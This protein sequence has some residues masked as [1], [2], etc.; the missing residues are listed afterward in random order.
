M[1]NTEQFEEGGTVLVRPP[2]LYLNVLVIATCGLV[3]ELI[4]GTLASYVLGDSV[5][6]FSTC[7]GVYLSAL[8][9][10]AWLSRFVD[11][12]TARCFI[13]VELGVALLGGLS[14][15]ILFLAFSHV[16][17]FHAALYGVVFAIGTLVG[18]ELP[19][20]MRILREQLEFKELVSRVLTF[21]YIGALVGSLLF[22]I[23]LVPSLGL[24]RTSLVFGMLNAAVALWGTWLLEPL[25]KKPPGPLRVRAAVVMV[26]LIVAFIKADRLTAIAEEQLFAN[27][28]V[29][30]RTTRYQRV[31]VTQG[32]SGFQLF[33][34]GNLQFNSIDEYRYHEALAHP[35]MLCCPVPK[36]VLVLGGGDGLA[37]REVLGYASVESVTLVDLD[38]G[39]TGLSEEFP[40]LKT[41]N[42][43]SLD[44]DR[45]QVV[46]DDA[47]IWLD[48]Y[49]GTSFDV[50]LIDFP[51]PNNFSLGKL[52]TRHFYRL[53][54]RH[55]A[56]GG[57]IGL[58]S[59]SPLVARG[60][61]WCV[62]R[63]MEAAGLE[64]RPYHCA[65][66]SF[67]VWGFVLASREPVALPEEVPVGLDFLNRQSLAAMF[68]LPVDLQ[69]VPVDINRLD[70]QVLVRYYDDEW[71]KWQPGL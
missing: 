40:P 20:L 34:N 58:Q 62:A 60:S 38:P 17:W 8:G 47:M 48:R 24:V 35:A 49:D 55:L 5:T 7:I 10:G 59:S 13:E 12:S 67:G 64:V 44:D 30:A 61:Y 56:D 68:Q 66:P 51:D 14:A 52:Y 22:P 69:P 2:L 45:V 53:V 41:L 9:V 57:T 37:V 23:L 16:S 65:V 70:N 25:L 29:Y 63:T 71:K 28:V 33:L 19:L 18:L 31:V 43:G 26:V 50:I 39:M 32:R 1:G 6:Q 46:N 3:Y 36:R 27:P 21:D 15:P 42:A 11:K 4:A 54:K